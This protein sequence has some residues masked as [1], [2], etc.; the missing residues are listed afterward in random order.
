VV[1]GGNSRRNAIAI[2]DR[3]I[4][5]IQIEYANTEIWGGL[6]IFDCGLID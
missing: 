5:K 1:T 2:G 4:T 3:L 6:G